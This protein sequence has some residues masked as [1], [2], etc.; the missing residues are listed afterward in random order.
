[1]VIYRPHRNTLIEA[2][3]ESKEFSDFEEMK[4]HICDY[5]FTFYKECGFSEP[6]FEI[7][8]IVINEEFSEDTRNGWKDT[9]YVCVK[10]IGKEIYP[11]PQCIGF[12]ATIY[13]EKG[14]II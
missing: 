1:M 4:K 9:R 8:D 11:F 13:G 5:W 14:D 2:M 10:R 7:S 3:E 12:C 6:P